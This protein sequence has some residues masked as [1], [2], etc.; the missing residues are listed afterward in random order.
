MAQLELELEIMYS[1]KG[2]SKVLKHNKLLETQAEYER[3]DSITN[4]LYIYK[5]QTHKVGTTHNNMSE[6]DNIV[7]IMYEFLMI[8]NCHIE[9]ESVC[10]K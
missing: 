1:S 5:K 7:N 2:E 10:M 4:P 3:C 9:V 6:K 8:L